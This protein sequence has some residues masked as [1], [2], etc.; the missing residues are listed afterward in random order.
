MK[1][2]EHITHGYRIGFDSPQKILKSLFMLHNESVN[3]WTHLLPAL[4]VLFFVLYL[5]IFVGPTSLLSDL[6]HRSQQLHEGIQVY[7]E[8]L[9]NFTF[10]MQVRN[11]H[12]DRE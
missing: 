7:S 8:A 10:V 9:E 2:N 12:E 5:L 11:F 1:D 3:V 6:H 4:I